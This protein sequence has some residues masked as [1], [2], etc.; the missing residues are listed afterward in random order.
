MGLS[1]LDSPTKLF[2]YL[3]LRFSDQPRI[4]K[5]IFFYEGYRLITVPHAGLFVEGG[6]RN[7]EKFSVAV[8]MRA[9]KISQIVDNGQL[10]M[11]FAELKIL[12][13]VDI[14]GCPHYGGKLSAV[15]LY[16]K[17]VKAVFLE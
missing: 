11:I 9:K 6:G 16:A 7:A 17:S 12:R 1:Y 3:I 8:V 10:D 14:V 15:Y 5:A 13:E 2:I 4:D